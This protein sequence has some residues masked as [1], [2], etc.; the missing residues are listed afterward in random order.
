MHSRFGQALVEIQIVNH[1][2]RDLAPTDLYFRVAGYRNG[3]LVQEVR[4]HPLETVY[5]NHVGRV[6]VGL[7]GSLSWYDRVEVELIEP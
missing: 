1:C 6:T 7:P 5:R 3:G 2:R 4:A